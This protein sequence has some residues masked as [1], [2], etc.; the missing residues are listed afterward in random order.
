MRAK[1][2]QRSDGELYES[3]TEAAHTLVDEYGCGNWKTVMAAITNVA[4]KRPH[5]KTAYGYG[6][7]WV[8]R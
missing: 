7:K 3:A 2:I 1:P 6:W 5:H 8:N 4:N